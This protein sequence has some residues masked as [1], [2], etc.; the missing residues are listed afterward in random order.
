M[1]A[2]VELYPNYLEIKIKILKFVI[3]KM[4]SHH[5]LHDKFEAVM[6]SDRWIGQGG[7]ANWPAY[8]LTSCSHDICNLALILFTIF[9]LFHRKNVR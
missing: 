1:S 6:F 7:P 8:L 3:S 9:N 5:T 4:G 2:P